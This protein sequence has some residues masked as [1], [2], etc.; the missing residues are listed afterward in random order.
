MVH[1]PWLEVIKGIVLPKAKFDAKYAVAIVA[2]LGTTIS[3]YLFIWQAAQEVE[4]LRAPGPRKSLKRAPAQGPDALDRI[5]MD[6]TIGMM[7]SNIVAIFIILTAAVTLHAHGKTD[8]QSASDAAQALKPI[9]GRFAFWLFAAGIVGTGLLAIPVLAGSTAYVAAGVLGENYGLEHKPQQAKVFLW[10]VDLRQH[11]RHCAEFH[12]DQSNQGAVLERG[13]QRGGGGADHGDRHADEHEKRSDGQIYH[14][15]FAA[16]YRLDRHRR[17]GYR[18]DRDVCY[19]GP[20]VRRRLIDSATPR[21][22][23]TAQVRRCAAIVAMLSFYGVATANADDAPYF[24]PQLLGAQYTF[25]GQWQRPL[26]A[27]YSGPL[28]LYPNGDHARSHTFGA[29]VGVPLTSRLALYVDMEMFRGEGISRSTGLGGLTNGD[30]IRGGGASLGRS[31]YVARAFF[32][33]DIPLG[34]ETTQVKRKMDQLP[35][36]A[37]RRPTEFQ[38][39][40]DGGQ[41]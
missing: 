5:G 35:W 38:D 27:P 17:D 33:Y 20:I 25:I 18:G 15:P 34:D 19:L 10:R 11:R 7:F 4:E 2:V 21:N 41:R 31:A 8:I 14:R 16:D 40:L 9:A 28:S 13:H 24:V 6:T 32:T 36:R 23:A 37:I 30:V 29:Y 12:P 26:H 3:P 22:P 1:V 39:R